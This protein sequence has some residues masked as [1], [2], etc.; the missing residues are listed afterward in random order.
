MATFHTSSKYHSWHENIPQW[1]NEWSC[2]A[3]WLLS[4]WCNYRKHKCVAPW[5]FREKQNTVFV[6]INLNWQYNSYPFSLFCLST[7]ALG[8]PRLQG[9]PKGLVGPRLQG[10]PKGLGCLPSL[11][12]LWPEEPITVTQSQCTNKVTMTWMAHSLSLGVK[13]IVG[14]IWDLARS[15]NIYGNQV[16]G[17]WLA[18][19]ADKATAGEGAR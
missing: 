9:G 13:P 15:L 3:C 14:P 12:S 6:S 5:W 10:G 8:G 7:S 16:S 18:Q 17:G 19:C 1:W 11:R 4:S 2:S